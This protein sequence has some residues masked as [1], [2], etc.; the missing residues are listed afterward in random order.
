MNSN[1]SSIGFFVLAFAMI[2]L[3][4][5]TPQLVCAVLGAVAYLLSWVSQRL[6]WYRPLSS[7]PA[8]KFKGAVSRTPA[9]AGNSRE[10]GRR[11]GPALY[12][13]QT[14]CAGPKDHCSGNF[15]PGQMFRQT[16][17][18]SPIK[19]PTFDSVNFNDQV[20]ELLAQI[21]PTPDSD[22]VVKKLS[23]ITQRV[24]EQLIPEIE[25]IGFTCT[26]L[27]GGT[28]FG[29]AVPEVD[30]VA[31]ISPSI[32]VERMRGKVSQSLDAKKLQK[33]V[34]RQFTQRL[35]SHGGFKFRRSNFSSSEPKV[36]LLAHIALGAR[37]LAI[38]MSFSVNNVTPLYNA[39]LLTECGRF[40][41][42]AKALILLVKR[43][44]KDRGICHAP[45]G[46]LPPYAWN[47]LVI[48]FLQVSGCHD[49]VLPPL[50]GFVASSGLA[51]EIGAGAKKLAE[52]IPDGGDLPE[53]QSKWVP[54]PP[55]GAKHSVAELFRNF[56][57]FYSAGIDLRTEAIS[58]RLGKRMPPDLSLEFHIVVHKNGRT[59]VAPTIEDP[60]EL[61]QNIGKCMNAWSLDRFREELSRAEELCE[62][63]A[64]LSQLLEPWKPGEVVGDDEM[65]SQSGSQMCGDDSSQT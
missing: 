64:S 61:T 50:E 16:P 22:R 41:P 51:K 24:L 53:P 13:G 38:P 48:F 5:E 25:V 62:Q 10:L 23:L 12:P 65:T 3:P 37:E 47:L 1:L 60:F 14:P 7:G 55:A 9:S 36:T 39:A 20:D 43:W 59:E 19:A 42:R 40:E 28:A 33:S 46:H 30:V 26:S 17:T 54:T 56:V 6:T 58:I 52:E 21:L 31:S 2:V 11:C 32:A 18:Q 45:K 57:R 63:D 27:K 15:V 35:V 4:I 44:C 34:L 29:V 8:N 49:S